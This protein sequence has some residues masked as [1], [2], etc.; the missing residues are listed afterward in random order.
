MSYISIGLGTKLNN[1]QR[2]KLFKD[3][4]IEKIFT[5]KFANQYSFSVLY[6][7]RSYLGLF[8]TGL[9]KVI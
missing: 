3:F 9:N 1:T 8:Y 7:Y 5:P 4:F 6:Q 2:D